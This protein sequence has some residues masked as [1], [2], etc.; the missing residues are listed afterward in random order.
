MLWDYVSDVRNAEQKQNKT[1]RTRHL[2][3]SMVITVSW[4][5]IL[6]VSQ[7]YRL[8]RARSPGP[9]FFCLSYS[10]ALL[11]GP[12]LVLRIPEHPAQDLICVLPQQ[13]RRRADSG[14]CVRVLDRRAT[15]LD[16]AR[17]GVLNL[18]HHPARQHLGVLERALNIIDWRK[19]Y[20]AAL[21]RLEPELVVLGLET[22]RQ[23]ANQGVAVGDTVPVGFVER[24]VAE[25][26]ELQDFTQGTELAVVAR[27]DHDV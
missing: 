16:L 27:T 20:S 7:G 14:L 1:K 2:Y 10:V 18:V 26:V 4:T 13:R 19:R 15:Q 11:Q 23:D 12:D 6:R 22:V 5:V 17:L 24:V 8:L 25:R 9:F 21:Q 3:R